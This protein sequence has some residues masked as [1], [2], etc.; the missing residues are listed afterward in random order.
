MTFQP[1]TSY[2]TDEDVSLR[3]SADFLHLC[4]RDQKLASGNDGSFLI[5]DPWTLL[6]AT[7]SFQANGLKPG[8]IILLTQ[9]LASFKPP[10]ESFVVQQVSP[11]SVTLRRK[12]QAP[13]MG[14]PPSGATGLTQVEFFATTLGPQ[15][16]L[17]SYDLNRRYG[18]DDFVAGRRSCDL[19]DPREVR[20]ATVLTV[21]YRQYMEMSRGSEERADLFATKAR[22]YKE[23]LSDLLARTI[24]H[25]ANKSG[26]PTS[27]QSISK[28][29]TRMSR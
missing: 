12:G 29:A 8:Q 24:I 4:P 7:V 1:I 25:W 3:A 10:G 27:S 5:S 16:E 13:G 19:F 23:E 28:M 22:M 18:I 6:S 2:A 26:S 11:G 9:P 17:A 20:D 15:I 21:L 14:Q